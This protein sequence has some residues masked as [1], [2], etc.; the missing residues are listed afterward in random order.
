MTSSKSYLKAVFF[1]C[2]IILFIACNIGMNKKDQKLFFHPL[3]SL[4][5]FEVR[6]RSSEIT[7]LDGQSVLKL[8]GMIVFSEPI[9]SDASIEVEILAQESCYPG[10]A[11]RI[12]DETNFELAYAVPH[13]SGQPDAIQY[14]PV[15]NGSNTWQL[16]NGESYQKAAEVPTGEWFSLRIN[17]IGHRAAIWVGDQPPLIIEKLAH[18]QTSGPIGL[19]AF[20]PA[21]FRNLKVTTQREM[22][23]QRGKSAQAPSGVI[24][25]WKLPGGKILTCEPTGILNLNRYLQPSQEGIKVFRDFHLTAPGKVAI[26]LGFSD[27][28]TLYIDGEEVFNGE[29]L[30]KGFDDIPS[31]GWVTSDYKNIELSLESGVH[32]IE[33]E[34]KVTEPFG[35]GFIIT[36]SGQNLVLQSP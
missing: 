8:D 24:S 28:L 22:E 19:W 2:I 23:D 3:N 33:A 27:K 29:H 1:F 7:E 12:A 15:F 11:F 4:T 21:F 16:F 31:R 30:F 18:P 17:I 6:A 13:V 35:W 34:L 26:S 20:K 5:G 9:I 14:D 36:L 32:K 10:I 25:A